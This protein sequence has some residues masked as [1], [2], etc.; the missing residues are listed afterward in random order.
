MNIQT[1]FL[2]AADTRLPEPAPARKL[3]AP[4][5]RAL[6]SRRTIRGQISLFVALAIGILLGLAIL[7]GIGFYQVS[8]RSDRSAVIAERALAASQFDTGIAHS[9]YHASR[10]A[11]TGSEDSIAAAFASLEDASKRLDRSMATDV[12]EATSQERIAWLRNQVSGFRPELEALRASVSAYGPQ[13]NAAML[14]EAIDVSGRLLSDQSGEIETELSQAAERAQHDLE[15]LKFWMSIG[16]LALI[17][18]CGLV[19]VLAARRMAGQVSQSLGEITGAMTALADGD[20]SIAIPGVERD[21]EIGEMARALVIF[22]ESAEALTGLQRQAR[23]D[24]RAMLRDLARGF[25]GGMG[26]VVTNVAAASHQ[27]EKTASSMASAASQSVDLVEDVVRRMNDTAT[28]MTSAA[29]ATDEFALSIG[30]IGKQAAQSASLAQETR[31]SAELADETV[32]ELARAAAEV[33]E[34]VDLI[35]SIADR[36]NLLAL[37]A[38]IEAARGGDAGRGFAVVASEVKEL[39][40]QTREATGNVSARMASM[41]ASTRSSAGALTLIGERIREVEATAT[42]IAGAVDQQSVSSRELARSLDM[43]VA[44]VGEIEMSIEQLRERARDTGMAADQLLDAAT[45]LDADA[46]GLKREAA[47]FVGKILAA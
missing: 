8:L 16:A 38:S 19:V 42:A 39:A 32:K 7:L 4:I 34:V 2:P 14:A 10:Y 29:A 46:S 23:E 31:A 43:A 11:V 5:R 41:Q 44:G 9:R 21:D 25:E 40:R 26:D 35:A 47:A 12:S 15:S 28:G 30:E 6:A 45:G 22:R 27:L 18:A 24:Q 37:N 36:T 13:E 33:G 1:K 3:P 20:R 17:L